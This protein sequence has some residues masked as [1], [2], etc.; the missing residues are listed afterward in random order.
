MLGNYDYLKVGCYAGWTRYCHAPV[1]GSEMGENSD[2]FVLQFKDRFKAWFTHRSIGKI[3][4]AESD[5][6]L[7]WKF[8]TLGRDNP[9]VEDGGELCQAINRHAELRWASTVSQPFVIEN[10]G[11]YHMWFTGRSIPYTG[12]DIRCAIGYAQSSDGVVWNM[13]EAPVLEAFEEHEGTSLS[14]PSV[15]YD[16]DL[17]LFRMWYT[18]GG[19][20]IPFSIGYAE[21]TDGV[22]WEKKFNKPLFCGSRKYEAFGVCAC[23]IVKQSGWYYMFYTAFEDPFKSRICLARSHDGISSWESHPENPIITWGI[24]GSWDVESVGVPRLLYVDEQWRMYY[25]GRRGWN[26]CSGVCVLDNNNFNFGNS[27]STI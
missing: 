7:H 23:H 19:E 27:S 17:N 25:T 21:S 1:I 9:F 24:P 14:Y 11:M 16:P 5:D 3:I 18:C 12:S 4:T 2:V 15:L 22:H 13:R 26:F 20:E 8:Y 6:G 10:G